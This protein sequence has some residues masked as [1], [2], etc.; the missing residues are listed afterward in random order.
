[1]ERSNVVAPSGWLNELE[2]SADRKRAET[3]K[4][5]SERNINLFQVW[6]KPRRV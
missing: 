5:E 6:R 2:F 3:N 4:E 1:M